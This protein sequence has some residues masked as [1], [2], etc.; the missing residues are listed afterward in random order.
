MDADLFA[1]TWNITKEY[2]PAKDKQHA[3]DH[4]IILLNDSFV[5]EEVFHALRDTDDFMKQAMDVYVDGDD[6]ELDNENDEE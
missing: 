3:A 5:D 4:I 6:N 1:A 2:I